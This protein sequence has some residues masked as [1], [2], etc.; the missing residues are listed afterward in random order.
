MAVVWRYGLYPQQVQ[1][2]N[3]TGRPFYFRARDGDWELWRGPAVA[4]PDYLSWSQHAKLVAEGPDT[5]LTPDDIDE[6]LALH[7]GRG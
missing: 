1:G 7:L 6:L 4:K 2:V 5:G 3:E